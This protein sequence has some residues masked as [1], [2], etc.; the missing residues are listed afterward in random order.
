MALKS[1]L[2][3]D[4]SKLAR[5]TL[6]RLL[7]KRNLDVSM[8]ASAREALD[9]LR[10]THPDVIFM[11]HLMPD[12]DGVEAMIRIKESAHT[13]HIPIVMCTGKEGDD[14]E[15]SYTQAG[16]IGFLAKPPDQSQLDAVLDLVSEQAEARAI[17]S[18]VPLESVPLEESTPEIPAEAIQS[19][20]DALESKFMDTLHK[21]MAAAN[22]QRDGL[23]QNHSVGTQEADGIKA[24]LFELQSRTD[25]ITRQFDLLK[26]GVAA[27]SSELGSLRQ[28]MGK[29]RDDSLLVARIDA[30]EAAIST[31]TPGSPIQTDPTSDEI[32][33]VVAEHMAK[34]VD[35]GLETIRTQL[36]D[37]RGSLPMMVEQALSEA[38][39]QADSKDAGA[40]EDIAQLRQQLAGLRAMN[41]FGTITLGTIAFVA[42]AKAFGLF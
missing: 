9:Y 5:I 15:K 8:C 2:L 29:A 20:M 30:L 37:L 28:E 26:A 35:Q 40:E 16:A 24:R 7:E 10:H 39:C 25:D 1:A 22:T 31:S 36:T 14:Y 23:E 12:M 19:Q 27:L 42:L 33:Q 32:Q 13:K 34:A 11:D 18:E 4:D 41:L 21:W 3:V 17:A 6:K 38:T